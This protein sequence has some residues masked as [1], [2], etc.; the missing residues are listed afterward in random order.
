[1][2]SQYIEELE[3]LPQETTDA[4]FEAGYNSVQSI[5]IAISDSLTLLKYAILLRISLVY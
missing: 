2:A 3:S 1:M 5:A 4:L